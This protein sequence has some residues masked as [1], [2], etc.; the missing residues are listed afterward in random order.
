MVNGSVNGKR[1]SNFELLYITW[2]CIHQKQGDYVSGI[3]KR[4]C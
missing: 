2:H 4:A 3:T 1:L